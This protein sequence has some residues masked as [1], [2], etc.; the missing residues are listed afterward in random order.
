M[1]KKDLVTVTKKELVTILRDGMELGSKAEAEYLIDDIESAIETIVEKLD[2]N[3]KV[4]IGNYVEVSKVL[5]PAHK[6]RNPKTG[7]TVDVPEKVSVKIKATPV[8]AKN[9]LGQ[10]E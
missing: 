8:V 6:A 3:S 10:A 5:V 7:E 1:A 4:K 2:V 9:L